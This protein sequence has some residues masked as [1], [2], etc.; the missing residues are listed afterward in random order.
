MKHDNQT[1]RD[2]QRKTATVVARSWGVPYLV[3]GDEFAHIDYTAKREPNG[4]VVCAIEIKNVN[5]MNPQPIDL[6]K[7][8]AVRK[9]DIK[10]GLPGVI[11]WRWKDLHGGWRIGW[12]RPRLW[13]W[14]SVEDW[15]ADLKRGPFK[16]I[17]QRNNAREPVDF[18]VWVPFHMFRP[19][20]ESPF[21]GVAHE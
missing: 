1:F 17:D 18:V 2:E 4:P 14:E 19:L 12:A 20:T 7:L 13:D 8:R 6:Y 3:E 5:L 15:P 16:R 11:V 21:H 9:W 10:H